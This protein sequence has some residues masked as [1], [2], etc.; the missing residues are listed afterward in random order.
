MSLEHNDKIEWVSLSKLKAHPK[1]PKK[2]T[3]EKIDRL[4]DLIK[5]QGIRAPIVVSKLSGHI[6]KGHG[7]LKALKKL[8]IK[9]APVIYQDFKDQE[10]EYAFL[11]SDNAV[12]TWDELDF[13]KINLD[14]Q[15]LGPDIDMHL[16]AIKDFTETPEEREFEQVEREKKPIECPECGHTF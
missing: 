2:H 10:Q 11:V 13:A 6:V 9:K 12:G 5:Y 7:T 4:A 15:E 8:E 14:I 3:S 16:L 1:N